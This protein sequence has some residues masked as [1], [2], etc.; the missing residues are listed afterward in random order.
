MGMALCLPFSFYVN[1]E[2]TA[3][4]RIN[5]LLMTVPALCDVLAT[6]FDATGLIYVSII[7]IYDNIICC[8]FDENDDLSDSF[9]K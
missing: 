7:N 2:K 5:P 4:K 6:I 1:R 9:N 3:K 8:A